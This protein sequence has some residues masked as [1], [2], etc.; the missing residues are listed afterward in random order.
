MARNANY[1]VEGN[2]DK[3]VTEINIKEVPDF[4]ISDF[5]FE[6]EK[7]LYKYIRRVETMNLSLYLILL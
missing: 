2:Y 1:I 6:D 3:P 7:A 4:N 5:D